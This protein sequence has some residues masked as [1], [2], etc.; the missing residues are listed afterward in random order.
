[1]E[2]QLHPLADNGI[3]IDLGTGIQETTMQ[4]IQ[5]ITACLDERSYPWMIEYVPAFTTITIYYDPLTAIANQPGTLPY[6]VVLN[7]INTLLIK[8]S[9][10]PLV[11]PSVI[12]IPVCYGGDLG[13]DLPFVALYNGLSTQE[14]IEIHSKAEYLVYMIGFAPGFPYIGGMSEKINVP[15]KNTPRLKIPSGSVGIAGSQTGIYP[16]ETPGGW[17]LIGRTPLNLFTPS[18][19][20]PSLLQAGDKIKFTPISLNEFTNWEDHKK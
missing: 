15:R 1:M 14:V 10:S 7:Q 4:K 6:D 13:P 17:Q 11:Q 5:T 2:Y 16:I 19:K 12:S 18:K 8:L 20:S 9:N 3:I